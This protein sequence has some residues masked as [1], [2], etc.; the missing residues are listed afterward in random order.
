MLPNIHEKITTRRR[1][2][3]NTI[4]WERGFGMTDSE[5]KLRYGS[6]HPL[7][8]GKSDSKEPTQGELRVF[9]NISKTDDPLVMKEFRFVDKL[10]LRIEF[11]GLQSMF[12]TAIC[13]EEL[14]YV[15]GPRSI[16]LGTPFYVIVVWNS[17]IWEYV[18][19]SMEEI[20]LDTTKLKYSSLSAYSFDEILTEREKTTKFVEDVQLLEFLGKIW[21]P[22]SRKPAALFLKH[23]GYMLNNG[24][25]KR[26]Y[27]DLPEYTEKVIAM[28]DAKPLLEPSLE[29]VSYMYPER[30]IKFHKGKLYTVVVG[31]VRGVRTILDKASYVSDQEPL[32]WFNME[33]R[34]AMLEELSCRV[35]QDISSIKATAE[36]Y[37][38]Y[39]LQGRIQET[40]DR[41]E[42]LDSNRM[43]NGESETDIINNL[44]DESR[45][46]GYEPKRVKVVTSKTKVV[47]DRSR[48]YRPQ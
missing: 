12:N 47:I 24:K 42:D 43:N 36:S 31:Y 23:S 14:N 38:K 9:K 30:D 32:E 27:R 2:M 18:S 33:Y 10:E 8:S 21:S 4:E 26:K 20:H 45:E 39:R 35:Q 46:L 40:I 25:G 48:Y 37:P 17:G 6:S 15:C 34:F 7:C 28:T 13:V 3:Y 1:T 44:L 22:Y 11:L 16:S 19:H 41:L 29:V 5:F